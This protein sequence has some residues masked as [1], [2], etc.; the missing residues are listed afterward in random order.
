MN[1]GLQPGKSLINGSFSIAMFDY[2]R[3][4]QYACEENTRPGDM[5]SHMIG[6]K[7]VAV[8]GKH[9]LEVGSQDTL[10]QSDVAIGN[11][12]K[13]GFSTGKSSINSVFSG[14]PCFG[15][16]GQTNAPGA[17]FID[18]RLRAGLAPLEDDYILESHKRHSVE[19][20][21]TAMQRIYHLMLNNSA[22]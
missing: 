19:D 18:L 10:R 21:A 4:Y 8:H 14:T 15:R 22:Q 1:G 17:T 5:T 13:I 3:L 20:Q 7:P 12:L 9:Q 11:P 6:V 16:T 2:R